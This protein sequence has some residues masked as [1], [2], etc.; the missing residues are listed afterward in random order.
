MKQSHL[1]A[2]NTVIIWAT[3]VL[4]MIPPLVLVPFLIRS[5]G[6]SGYGE[7]ALIW[8]L[9]MAVE[10]LEVSLQSG[11]IKYGAAFLAQGR[12]GDLNRVLSST[13]VFSV[14]LGL[15]S[16]LAIGLTGLAAFGGSPGMR[17]SLLIVGAMMLFLAP[18]TP[19]M[20]IIRAKQRHYVNSLAGIASQYAGL[21]ITVLWF[22]LVG[23]SVEALIAILAGTLLISRLAQVPLAYGLVPGLRNS[24]RLFDRGTFRAV[25]GFG[26]MVVVLSLCLA[27]NSTGLRWLSGL[28]VSTGFVAHLAIFLMPG[29][30]L[31]QVVQAMTITVMPAAS[32]YEASENRALLRELFLRS[33]R[34]IV[35]LVSAALLAAVFLVRDV[36]RI[37]VG[38]GYELLGVYILINLGGVAV[39]MSA[40][41]AHQMLKGLGALRSLFAAYLTGLV[42][43]PAAVFVAALRLG[44]SPYAAISAGLLLGNITAGVLQLRACA[45]A[46]R[47][48]RRE[49]LRRA[50][51]QPL[52]PVAAGLAVAAGLGALTDADGLGGRLAL[53]GLGVGLAFGGFYLFIASPE[54]RRQLGDFVLMIR[55]RL[56]RGKGRASPRKEGPD[57]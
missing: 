18:T 5:L 4:Q 7:Y 3:T 44:E 36:L 32:A 19:Y 46:V 9:L 28:L 14:G 40:S 12:I 37:W 38:P 26:T 54:E 10:Q 17:G 29:V 55:D 51:L 24:I 35:L 34:Y 11:G 20:G 30:M 8:S 50:V 47:T 6:D 42:I 25:I 43:I 16:G 53:A 39:L 31:A 52:M 49:L 22:R 41:C 33:T 21:L 27:A 2:V 15:L 23:P 56:R 57:V 13:F 45:R 1:I 48:E